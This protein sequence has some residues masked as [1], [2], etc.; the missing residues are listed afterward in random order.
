[1]QLSK[2][3]KRTDLHPD[4]AAIGN[5]H[6]ELHEASHPEAQREVPFK[7]VVSDYST[8]SGRAD[9]VFE[10]RID[11]CKAT[12]SKPAFLDAQKGKPSMAHLTQ[13]VCYMMEFDLSRG[14][15]VYGYF[16]KDRTGQLA[17]RGTAVI[18]VTVVDDKVL[19]QGIDSGYTVHDLTN[20]I[21]QID[22]WMQTD[23]PAPRPAKEGYA[24]ACKYCP[25]AE[26]CARADAQGLMVSEIKSE[27]I[28][29]VEAKVGPTPKPQKEK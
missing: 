11:E 14:R 1:M 16:L 27:A 29:L 4:Y 2:G 13:L 12:F 15:I 3:A 24:S 10:G 21:L 9:F 8:L 18:D 28:E 5:M 25:L 7:R 19:V 26:L 22:K 23:E 6:E 20:T 17:R